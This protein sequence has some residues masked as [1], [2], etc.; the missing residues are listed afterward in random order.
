MNSQRIEQGKNDYLAMLNSP[1]YRVLMSPPEEEKNNLYVNSPRAE[2][3]E[4]EG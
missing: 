3:S 2:P 4:N 1:D